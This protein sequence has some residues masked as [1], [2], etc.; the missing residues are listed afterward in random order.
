MKAV[1]KTLRVAVC[2]LLGAGLLVA[3]RQSLQASTIPTGQKT[4]MSATAPLAFAGQAPP[5]FYDKF[6]DIE[7]DRLKWD[8]YGGT[9][10]VESGWL[11]LP[12][13]DI[14]SIPTFSCGTLQGVI[15]SSDW[16]PNGAFTDSSFGFEIWEGA[17]GKCHHG[18]V[19]KGSGQLGLLHSK[20]DAEGNC[21]GQ[22]E[23]IPGRHPDDPYYQDYRA[24]PSWETI[25]A[26]GTV[27]FTLDW[28]EGVTLEVSGGPSSGRVHMET[29]PAIPGVPL[30]IRLYAEPAETYAIDSIRLYPCAAIYLPTV[31]RD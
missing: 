13:A 23:A 10:I 19:L 26:A 8:V 9:P 28:S 2:I 25:R 20:P 29:S 1:H 14:Q 7:L 12:S 17:D 31:M 15:R 30:K 27:T 22:S 11:L 3:V 16:Q 4:T 6:D 21:A 24:I 18:V 5:L